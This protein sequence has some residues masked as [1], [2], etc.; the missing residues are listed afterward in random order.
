M[1]S[2][3][4]LA[5]ANPATDQAEL[6]QIAHEFPALRPLVAANPAAYDGLLDWLG[7]FGDPAVDAALTARR[8]AQSETPAAEPA[9]VPAATM[10]ATG[11]GWHEPTRDLPLQWGNYDL[12]YGIGLGLLL[13]SLIVPFQRIAYELPG[14]PVL[15]LLIVQLLIGLAGVA[16]MPSSI[17]RRIG[18]GAIGLVAPFVGG[19]L[20]FGVGGVLAAA[21]PLLVWL[22][23][24]KRIGM[25][26]LLVIPAA[27]LGFASMYM[28]YWGSYDVGSALLGNILT[29][30]I[31]VGLA[32]AARAI[33]TQRAP[34]LARRQQEVAAQQALY[35]GGY[36]QAGY[37]AQ[38]APA[39]VHPGG[40]VVARP[41][42]PT[43]TMAVLALVFGVGGGLLG[44]I[45]GHLARGQIRRSG[46]AGWGLASAGMVLGYIGLSVGVVATIVYIVFIA[47]SLR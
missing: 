37:P 12:R 47:M 35:V 41:G 2:T 1:P 32:W 26:Y 22:V 39:Y 15:P 25:T 7:Q 8:G 5:A 17:G 38:Y 18:A 40:P 42:A 10:V 34:I 3:Q 31:V 19:L 21:A 11:T 13:V 20:Y 43:N 28:Q 45:L 27:L 14:Y 29:A 36:P 23:V 24:R 9:A 16:V 46:E 4:E 33:H 30:A 6:A 44:I